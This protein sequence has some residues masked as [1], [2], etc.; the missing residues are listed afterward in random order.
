[1]GMQSSHRDAVE[2]TGYSQQAASTPRG[3]SN[4]KFNGKMDHEGKFCS[5]NEHGTDKANDR[6]RN[7][8][9]EPIFGVTRSNYS[10]KQSI[11]RRVP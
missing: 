11:W 8:D 10:R 4:S 1:M 2:S 9:N 5:T 6:S 3:A 7:G